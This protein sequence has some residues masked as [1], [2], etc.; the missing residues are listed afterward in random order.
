MKNAERYFSLNPI[1]REAIMRHM[2]PLTP[3]PPRHRES[4]IVTYA[5]KRATIGDYIKVFRRILKSNFAGT[6]FKHAPS[7]HPPR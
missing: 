1:E 2:W 5:D 4:L 3:V 6:G 7:I